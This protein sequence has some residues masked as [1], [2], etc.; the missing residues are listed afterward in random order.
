MSAT[1]EAALPATTPTDPTWDLMQGVIL[2]NHSE[3]VLVVR[4]TPHVGRYV[5]VR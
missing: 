1:P 2:G 4:S 3:P 5:P